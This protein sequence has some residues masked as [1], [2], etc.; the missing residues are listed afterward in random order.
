MA[1]KKKTQ[2][3]DLSA[4]QKWGIGV[5]ITAA[6]VTAAGAYF[7]YGSKDAEKNRKKVRSWMLKAKGEVLEGLERAQHMTREEYEQLVNTIAAA[8]ADLQDASKKDISEFKKEMKAHWDTIEQY[9]TSAAGSAKTSAKRAVKTAQ[10][11]AKK[12]ATKAA[13]AATKTAKKAATKAKKST[14]TKKSASK[15]S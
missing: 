12:K 11:T 13:K 6:A 14:A 4:E 15:K 1:K 2:A 7:L 5:G 9:A 8:Y 3:H 10:K